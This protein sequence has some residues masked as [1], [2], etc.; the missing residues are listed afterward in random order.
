MMFVAHDWFAPLA[1][2]RS[3]SAG[4]VVC[5][6]LIG[7]T[8]W[9]RG[10]DGTNKR[11]EERAQNPMRA[12]IDRI[13][14]VQ[15]QREHFIARRDDSGGLGN[16]MAPGWPTLAGLQDVSA[17]FVAD[18]DG[19]RDHHRIAGSFTGKLGPTG[20]HRSRTRVHRRM[21]LFLHHRRWLAEFLVGI[22]T[23]MNCC[24]GHSE[25]TASTASS[26]CRCPGQP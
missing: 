1:D 8:A 3:S 2:G 11:V 14:A 16:S 26:P 5:A 9:W 20:L 10:I 15:P 19:P 4:G 25:I 12:D 24:C 21:W 6:R 17:R 18:A 23:P 13:I 7:Q 22:C